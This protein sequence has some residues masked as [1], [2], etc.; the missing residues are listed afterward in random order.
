MK[1]STIPTLCCVCLATMSAAG[2]SHWWSVNQFVTA[3]HAGLIVPPTE[4]PAVKSVSPP[5][6]TRPAATLAQ[7]SQPSLPSSDQKNFYEA[8]IKKMD[9]LENKNRDLENAMS[10][11][12]RDVMNL[13]FRADTFSDSFRPLP[14][15]Q[16]V[17]DTTLSDSPDDSSGVLPVLAVPV[18]E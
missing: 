18:D 10:E 2:V 17:S 12:N 14:A 1:A 16:N 6:L 4:P 5:Q 9:T 11:T 7:T 8:L 13:G 3:F 15:S